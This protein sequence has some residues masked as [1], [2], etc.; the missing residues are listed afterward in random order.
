M[1]FLIIFH[2][3]SVH[4]PFQ[5]CVWFPSRTI[6][7]PFNCTQTTSSSQLSKLLRA[8]T[9]DKAIDMVCFMKPHKNLVGF[10]CT[11]HCTL[12]HSYL[13]SGFFFI[14]HFSQ[15]FPTLSS[16]TPVL[17]T[18]SISPPL[19]FL[20]HFPPLSLTVPHSHSLPLSSK[21]FQKDNPIHTVTFVL[22]HRIPF[23]SCPPPTS[24][25]DEVSDGV[26]D[27]ILWSVHLA[28]VIATVFHF[29]VCMCA[30]MYVGV[31]VCVY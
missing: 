29:Q 13:H 15:L 16:S 25:E 3:W 5:K 23:N 9:A 1:F 18:L 19:P 10:K 20:T 12:Q 22:T 21:A 7:W 2:A 30:C 24:D 27:D 11:F 17:S 6:R 14:S 28:C 8:Y 31:F 4:K 26:Q